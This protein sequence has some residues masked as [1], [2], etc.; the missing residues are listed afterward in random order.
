METNPS[1]WMSKDFSLAEVELIASRLKNG[2]AYG[3]DNIPS[4]FLKYA[5]EEAFVVMTALFTKIKSSGTFP[6]GWNCGRITLIHR[7]EG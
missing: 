5:P 6:Q 2:R 1:A 7:F 3:I 4:E